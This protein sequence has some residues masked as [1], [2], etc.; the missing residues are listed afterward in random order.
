MTARTSGPAR[1]EV[2]Q[3]AL[4]GGGGMC[5]CVGGGVI[6]AR[7][8]LMGDFSSVCVSVCE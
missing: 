6:V 1:R 2:G 7:V 3:L 8:V 5:V 4:G